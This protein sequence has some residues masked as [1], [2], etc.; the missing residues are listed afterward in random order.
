MNIKKTTFGVLSSG[1]KARL[2]T[3]KAGDLRLSLTDFGAAWTSLVVPSRTQGKA[4]VLLGFPTLEGYTRQGPYLGAT[5]GR[6][7]NR[8]GGGAFSLG[9][10]PFSLFLNEKKAS[11]HGGRRGFDK[12]LWKAE[13]FQETD[14]AFVCFSLESPD[15]DEGFPGRV[16]VV[17]SYGLTKANE[18][19]ADYRAE[20]DQDTPINL[21]NHAY[22]NLA[23]EG[24]G[25]I[26]D[27]ELQLNASSYLEV[28]G[29]LIPTGAFLPTAGGPFDFSERKALRPGA[30][31][32]GGGYDHCFV[33]D[34]DAG[35][36]RHCAEVFEPRSGRSMRVFTTQPALQLYTGNMLHAL[37]GK[38]GSVY[39]AHAGFCLETQHLPDS[40]NR[41]E[42]PSA[43]FGPSRPYHERSVFRF[44]W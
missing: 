23:G 27:H 19:I 24:A 30:E 4:D 37:A 18:L 35:E 32:A 20:A 6:F 29:D 22:F 14:G 13:T 40:P 11:L 5:I 31:A 38:A 34:G 36:L 9:G 12:R 43:I 3:L 42:F 44:D 21:T 41:P 7:A 33:I 2:Y 1:K 26:L 39:D 8:I 15:G 28:D 16:K 25:S 10:V 17:V